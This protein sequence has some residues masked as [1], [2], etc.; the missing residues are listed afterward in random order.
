M[1]QMTEETN[2]AQPGTTTIRDEDRERRLVLQDLAAPSLERWQCRHRHY[3]A[4][5]A[6]L[7]GRH[8]P[9]GSRVLHVGCGVGDLLAAVGGPGSLGIDL[10]PTVIDIARRRHPELR[11]RAADPQYFYLDEAFDY[12]VL[13]T[14]LADSTDIQACLECAREALEPDGRLLLCSYNALWGPAL[15]LA[16]TIGLRRRTREQNWLGPE[17]VDNLLRLS[18]FDA[19]SRSTHVLVPARVPAVAPLVNRVLPAIWPFNHLCLNQFVVARHA[20]ARP[21]SRSLSCTVVIP[22][23]NERGNIEPAV[24]RLPAIGSSTEI[25]FVDGS[26]SDGT[27][28]AGQGHRQGGRRA[29]RLRGRQRRRPD[30]PRRRPDGAAGG[31][32]TLLPP[33]RRRH[34]GVRQR[35]APRLSHAGTGHAVPQQVR[36]PLLQPAVHVAA[37]ATLP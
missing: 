10:S 8:I 1:T 11:F 22:T 33:H 34:G 14:V 18:G 2:A 31:P 13:D 30:D 36:E 9:L 15:R 3:Y 19:I 23:R 27:P 32:A 12:V 6:R 20:P 7:F 28:D 17:D 5:V 35:H 25:I 4:M 21:P 26:S 16:A 37:G 29:P 24:R